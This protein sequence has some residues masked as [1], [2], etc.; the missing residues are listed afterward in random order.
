MMTRIYG[1]TS[2]TPAGA[3]INVCL[4]S[5]GYSRGAGFTTGYVLNS[6]REKKKDWNTLFTRK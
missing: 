1:K 6:L 3:Q 2:G 5:G 4:N